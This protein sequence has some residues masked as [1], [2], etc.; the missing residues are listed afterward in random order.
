[1]EVSELVSHNTTPLVLTFSKKPKAIFETFLH[2]HKMHI[3][4]FHN[5]FGGHHISKSIPLRKE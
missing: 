2:P 3:E 4:K 1:M 5:V